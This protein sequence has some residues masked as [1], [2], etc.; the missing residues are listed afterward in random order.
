[1]EARAFS[2]SSLDCPQPGMSY[3]Q[4]ITP[5]YRVLL[6]ADG[7]RFDVRTSG[8]QGR[9]CRRRKP[10]DT[11]TEVRGNAPA[12]SELAES[13]RTQLA[14]QL[15]T[16]A[17]AI[18]MLGIRNRRPGEALPGC[19]ADCEERQDCGY[20]IQLRYEQRRYTYVATDGELTPCPAIATS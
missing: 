10:G 4:V 16:S 5:G 6:E 17:S 14:A 11:D 1:M 19:G 15:D 7:R 2:D 20:V 13:A 12:V 3:L 9:I 18:E 8:G